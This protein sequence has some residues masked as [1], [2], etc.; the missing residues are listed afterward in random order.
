MPCVLGDSFIL[1]VSFVS[2]T[3]LVIICYF[4]SAIMCL[5]I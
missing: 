4:L 2:N 5:H 1:P 3:V